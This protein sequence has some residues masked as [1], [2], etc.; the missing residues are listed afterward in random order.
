M[1]DRSFRNKSAKNAIA[2]FRYVIVDFKVFS[3]NAPKWCTM[4]FSMFLELRDKNVLAE[5]QYVIVAFWN[6]YRIVSEWSTKPFLK[7]LGLRHKNVIVERPYVIADIGFSSQMASTWLISSLKNFV[8][9]VQLQKIKMWS[10]KLIF[11]SFRTRICSL[12]TPCYS[13]PSFFN[14][15]SI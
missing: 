6:S 12:S 9:F 10:L 13:L 5:R 3:R 14:F 11:G 8:A 15:S 4:L 7:F 1:R 2:V